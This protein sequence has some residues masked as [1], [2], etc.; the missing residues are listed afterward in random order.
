MRRKIILSV[1]G[2]LLLVGLVFGVVKFLP[3]LLS[4]LGY[5]LWLFLPFVASFLVS[6]LVNPFAD[7]LQK[8]LKMPRS[9]SAILVVLVTVGLVGGI[10]TAKVE[11][12]LVF[13]KK[14]LSIHKTRLRY[15]I[16]VTTGNG[17]VNITVTQISYLYSEEWEE[18]KPTGMGGEIYRA[19]EWITDEHALNK[20]GTKVLPL[21]GKFRRKTVDR[22]EELFNNA[23]DMFEE[24]IK[25]EKSKENETKVQKRQFVIE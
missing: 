9:L 20:K 19:E 5:I 4:G 16:I 12:W 8:R 6:L 17:A 25:E 11:D 23:M 14:F 7:A 1:L 22:M 21:S 24:K 10:I 3:V 18:M 2:L 15:Q 13:R